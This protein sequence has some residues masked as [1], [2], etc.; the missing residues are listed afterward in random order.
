MS[1][2]LF[3][4]SKEPERYLVSKADLHTIIDNKSVW[5]ILYLIKA[6][7]ATA[8]FKKPMVVHQ[9]VTLFRIGKDVRG[10]IGGL[11]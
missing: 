1:P 7:P 4:E 9:K 11:V 10:T 2:Q 5:N 8:D 6:L 3:Q